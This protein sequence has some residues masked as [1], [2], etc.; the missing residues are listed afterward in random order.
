MIR[1]LKNQT[2]AQSTTFKKAFTATIPVLAGY[3]VLGSAFGIL[4]SSKG[5]G[6]LWAAFMSITMYSG[7]LQFVAVGL[8]ADGASFLSTALMALLV[9][10][11]HIVYGISMLEKYR[12]MGKIKPYLIFAM[13]DETYALLCQSTPPNDDAKKYYFFVSLLNHIYW[14]CGGLL[15]TMIGSA[16]K[17]NTAGVDFAMTA[18]FVVIFVEKWE[19]IK[20]RIPCVTGIVCTI[21]CL[22]C[23]G[24][25]SFL[26]PSII[27]ITVL[28]LVF[29][30]IGEKKKN[31]ISG[32][33]CK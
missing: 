8:L 27:A 33:N 29:G 19:D 7:S 16:L 25:E 26:I 12:G 2:G 10:S 13:T 28:L 21:L 30:R 22:I 17:I 14:I 3:L 24:K 31:G 15:G 32:G 23:F 18:L 1:S 5:Y 9:N 4:L 6:C 20:N 11:R